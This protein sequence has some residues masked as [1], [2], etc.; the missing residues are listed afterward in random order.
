MPLTQV[1]SQKRVD[2]FALS[3]TEIGESTKTAQEEEEE[4]LNKGNLVDATH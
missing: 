4:I 3:R 1:H 2:S